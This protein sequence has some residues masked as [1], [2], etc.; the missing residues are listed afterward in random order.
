MGCKIGEVP[1][2]GLGD[3]AEKVKI[4][5]GT[6][7]GTALASRMCTTSPRMLLLALATG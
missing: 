2:I 4:I 6:T 7:A 3:K 5:F 1:R